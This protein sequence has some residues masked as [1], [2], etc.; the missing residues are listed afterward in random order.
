MLGVAPDGSDSLSARV[1][2]MSEG[3]IIAEV[4]T[5]PPVTAVGGRMAFAALINHARA[6][7]LNFTGNVVGS[8]KFPVEGIA[9]VEG[10]P[11]E[12]RK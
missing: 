12:F 2:F 11:A 7:E 3:A 5:P 10:S 9:H 8:S 1:V 4:S 6:S